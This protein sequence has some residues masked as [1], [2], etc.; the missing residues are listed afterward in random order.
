MVHI[1]YNFLG[2]P[3]L[4]QCTVRCDLLPFCR[5]LP[6]SLVTATIV[7]CLVCCIKTLLGSRV[8]QWADSGGRRKSPKNGDSLPF[9][10]IRCTFSNIWAPFFGDFGFHLHQNLVQICSNEVKDFA[11]EGGPAMSSVGQ[12]GSQNLG[13]RPQF[14]VW[15]SGIS[16]ATTGLFG[17]SSWL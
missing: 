14:A 8:V 4:E 5:C 11:V 3:G 6:S 15:N 16:S 1:T 2:T 17:G 7:E 12:D 13:I 10:V 9:S